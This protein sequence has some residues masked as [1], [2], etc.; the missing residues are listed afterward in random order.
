MKKLIIMV[1]NIG[2]GKSTLTK[3]YQKEGYV[4]IA[5]DQLRYAIGGGDYVFNLDYE[6]II[7]NTELYM[8]DNFIDLEANILVDEVG[9][10]KAMRARY[11]T[12][13]KDKGYKITVIV[14]PILSK[15]ESVN[16]RLQNPH[17]Q[18]DR[19]LWNGIWEKFN[20]LYELPSKEE[21][22]DEIIHL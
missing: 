19:K 5:R 12:P 7:W 3:K 14:M 18:Y 2:S 1:G 13:A 9:I 10:T 6:P 22:I 4:I 8:V 20:K 11:I 15:K 17:G 21:G 16:R